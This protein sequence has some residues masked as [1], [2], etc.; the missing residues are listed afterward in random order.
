MEKYIISDTGVKIFEDYRDN[1]TID[2]ENPVL[3]KKAQLSRETYNK[4]K[5]KG[6]SR[7]G[8]ENSEDARTW[9]IFRALQLNNNIKKYYGLIGINDDCER[10]L[11]WGLDS[12]TGEFDKNL[13][14]VLDNIEP[15]ALWN[16]QQTEPD[17]I[18]IGKNSVVFNESKL[19]K[20]GVN[21]NAWNRKEEFSDKHELYKKYAEGYFKKELIENFYVEGRRYYQLIRNYIVGSNFAAVLNKNFYLVAIVNKR[22]KAISGLSHQ[23][24]FE[25]F[26]SKLKDSSQCHLLTWD[27]LE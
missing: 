2:K 19:G 5:V 9:N 3:H 22:N 23:E 10:I 6:L 16:I 1:I 21:I 25:L 13:K 12:E 24:E 26:R 8:S 4:G 27:K 7:L 15:P 11:F 14:S 17:I 18:I 20:E